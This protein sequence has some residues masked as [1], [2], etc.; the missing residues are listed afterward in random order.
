MDRNVTVLGM[1]ENAPEWIPL[2]SPR[3]HRGTQDEPRLDL[4]DKSVNDPSRAGFPLRRNDVGE[5]GDKAAGGALL[6]DKRSDA[7]LRDLRQLIE[8]ARHQ[9]A[10]AADAG[11]TLLYWQIGR[12]IGTEVL[13]G[14]R[15]AYGE[16]II[17]TVAGELEAEHG[18]GFAEKNL[19][20]MVQ[21]AEVFPDEQIVVTL[22]R[23]LSWSH[24]LALIPLKEALRRDFYA[25]MCR[26]QRWSV[27]Q[28]RQHIDSMLYERTALSRRP[29][30]VIEAQIEA[31]REQDALSTDLVLKAPYVLDFL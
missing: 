16:Q 20:R 31:L 5:K 6:T 2:R 13:G 21:F 12:R 1:P 18:R 30:T 9:T 15:A 4:G 25:E 22:L 19:R 17:A 11:L 14:E 26:A 3:Q 23:Q 28:L 8:Q 27:R 29:D 10:S 7:L 24:F